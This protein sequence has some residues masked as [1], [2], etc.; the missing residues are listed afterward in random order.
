M[1]FETIVTKI[2]L[3]TQLTTYKHNENGG[4]HDPKI[5]LTPRLCLDGG[6][7]DVKSHIRHCSTL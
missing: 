7:M 4:A 3:H 1:K 6:K 2:S 5:L